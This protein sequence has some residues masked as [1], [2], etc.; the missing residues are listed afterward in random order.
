MKNKKALIPLF[1][2]A[3]V[4]IAAAAVVIIFYSKEKASYDEDEDLKEA[5]FTTQS[6]EDASSEYEYIIDRTSFD[7]SQFYSVDENTQLNNV[8]AYIGDRYAEPTSIVRFEYGGVSFDIDNLCGEEL[9]IGQFENA[10]VVQYGGC[11]QLKLQKIS[12]YST[13]KLASGNAFGEY[14]DLIGE[15]DAIAEEYRAECENKMLYEDLDEY[16]DTEDGGILSYTPMYNFLT[17]NDLMFEISLYTKT[18]VK[19]ALSAVYDIPEDYVYNNADTVT[20]NYAFG[21]SGIYVEYIED[22]DTEHTAY[23][24]LYCDDGVFAA[25]LFYSE[26]LF[27][28]LEIE[29]SQLY[30]LVAPSHSDWDRLIMIDAEKYNL[31]KYKDDDYEKLENTDDYV[32][33]CNF[34]NETLLSEDNFVSAVNDRILVKNEETTYEAENQGESTSTSLTSD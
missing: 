2:G 29:Q 7:V 30:Y 12:D 13:S 19:D 27:D 14:D 17:D 5:D 31:D 21:T 3:F 32:T 4:I 15:Y 24:L 28:K 20:D 34:S 9:L 18:E 25:E 8:S 1:V 16:D 33:T 11:Y 6:Y 26:S 22:G 23:Y 10:L